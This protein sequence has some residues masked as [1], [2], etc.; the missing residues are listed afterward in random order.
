MALDPSIFSRLKSKQDFD[1]EREEFEFRKRQQQMQEQM[2]QLQLEQLQR[3]VTSPQLPFEGTGLDVSA[4]NEAYKR[5]VAMGMDDATARQQALDAVLG[6]K[7]QLDRLGNPITR[8]PIFGMPA[9]QVAYKPPREVLSAPMTTV[10]V[11]Q[12]MDQAAADKA[13]L[14]LYGNGEQGLPPLEGMAQAGVQDRVM[15]NV[16]L[17]EVP[18]PQQPQISVPD[19][20]GLAPYSQEDV[21]KAQAMA[22]IEL[23]IKQQEE[24]LKR[25]QDKIKESK[26]LESRKRYGEIMTGD[27]LRALEVMQEPSV[28]AK[29]GT[30]AP[31]G[32][33]LTSAGKLKALTD[34]ITA[35]ASFDRLADLR[36]TSPTGGAVGA[37]SDPERKALGQTLGNISLSDVPED[38]LELN[39]KRMYNVQMDAI[40]GTPEQIM[41]VGPQVGL[42]PQE[43]EQISFRFPVRAINPQSL[44][45]NGGTDSQIENLLNK[46]APR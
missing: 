12:P 28:F 32:V 16:V 17:P 26:A 18:M 2:G 20:G 40:H 6:S 34:S 21:R 37:L 46:Y 8:Q 10:P 43:I 27:I 1:R 33:S 29:S 4:A 14:D 11:Q 9:S 30:L 44:I 41:Q 38:Q 36:A 7:V 42:S 35:N 3:Q 31:T 22:Q 23:Q 39:L 15:P 5:N 19:I 24:A 45:K 13:V 25:E